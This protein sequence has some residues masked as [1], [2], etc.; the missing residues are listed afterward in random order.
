MAR[1]Y[2]SAVSDA[3]LRLGSL[4]ADVQGVIDGLVDKLYER[5]VKF[6]NAN[7]VEIDAA[8]L[9]G[10]PPYLLRE[11]LVLV[12]RRQCWPMRAMGF[13]QWDQLDR[14]LSEESPTLPTCKI[15]QVFPGNVQ[16]EFCD[17]ILR[18]TRAE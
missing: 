18:L 13:V 2:N 3:L 5:A 10:Q 15:K 12:W 1:Q 7:S 8:R 16:A 9:A 11:L 4:A 14:M 6:E 17:G